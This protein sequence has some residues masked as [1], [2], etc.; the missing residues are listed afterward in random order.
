MTIRELY[1]SITIQGAYRILGWDDAGEECEVLA[2][3]EYFESDWHL[4]RKYADMT[5]TYMYASGKKLHIEV[6][7]Q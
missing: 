6:V 4:I 3:G 7:I 1:D 5:I 2:D